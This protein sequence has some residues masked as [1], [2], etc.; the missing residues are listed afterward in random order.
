MSTSKQQ[1][2]RPGLR[3]VITAAILSVS[4]FGIMRIPLVEQYLLLPF[5]KAQHGLACRIGGDASAPI[6]VG[7]SCSASDV[8]ALCLGFVLAFPVP[9]R[10]RLLGAALGM[11]FI[12]AVNTVRIATLSHAI[13]NREWFNLLH[14]YIWPGIL[15]VVVSVFVFVWMSLSLSTGSK[16]RAAGP[17]EN[18]LSRPGVQFVLLT[19]LFVALFV[20]TSRWWMHS[21]AILTVANWV[22]ACGAFVIRLFGGQAEVSGNVL[23]TAS[24][25]FIVTQ[26]CIM[27]PLIPAYFA[28]AFS[29][30]MSWSRRGLVLAAALPVFFLLGGA[31]LLVLAFPTRLVGSHLVAIHGFYQFLLAAVLIVL[32]A[33]VSASGSKKF[34]HLF[35]PVLTALVAAGSTAVATGLVLNRV[36]FG[37]A[38]LIQAGLS[39][40]GHE[41]QDPQGALLIMA[42]YQL[43]LFVGLWVAW[44]QKVPSDRFYKGLAALVATQPL[45]LILIWEWVHHTG[46]APHVAAI[47]AW[48]VIS[49][50]LIGG[51]VVRRSRAPNARPR[52]SPLETRNG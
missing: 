34:A 46:L 16:V 12:A 8:I 2:A 28:A 30:P 38:S 29:L 48:S 3:F 51:W 11:A 10:K 39:H 23:R 50:L 41:Y 52:L 31:R 20:G 5:T 22:A 27:T 37:L 32:A 7:L 44:G 35:R 49:V 6:S 45:F 15:L 21:S 13:E 18:L 33:I 9:W 1:N 40:A 14:V 17:Q 4:L 42:P 24:G 47:R 36:L 26:E 43:G 25:G 19:I